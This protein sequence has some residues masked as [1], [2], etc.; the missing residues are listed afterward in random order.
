V[1]VGALALEL[2]DFFLPSVCIGC[3]DH[4]SLERSAELVCHKRVELDSERFRLRDVD[5]VVSRWDRRRTT[6]IVVLNVLDGTRP[7]RVPALRL[8]CVH[9]QTGSFMV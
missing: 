6:G 1:N 2:L 4:I 5:A 7:C 3:Q 8:C 9:R